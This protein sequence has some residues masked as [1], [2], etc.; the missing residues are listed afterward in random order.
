MGS[1][2][3]KYWLL[4]ATHLCNTFWI[5]LLSSQQSSPG[6]SNS[7]QVTCVLNVTN[8]NNSRDKEKDTRI[9]Q[10]SSQ[11]TFGSYCRRQFT[12]DLQ[13]VMP[14]VCFFFYFSFFFPLLYS[15]LCSPSFVFLV[16]SFSLLNRLCLPCLSA[17]FTISP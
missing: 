9:L 2:Q 6:Q 12:N 5:R 10:L 13:P 16:L 4:K 1:I 7:F 17:D 15:L 3:A 11:L 8:N 14:L